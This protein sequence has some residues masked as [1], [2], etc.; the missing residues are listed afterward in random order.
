MAGR[1][2]ST[3]MGV[4]VRGLHRFGIR[5]LKELLSGGF[6]VLSRMGSGLMC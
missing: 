3:P 4:H 2:R 5:K 6:R 1:G